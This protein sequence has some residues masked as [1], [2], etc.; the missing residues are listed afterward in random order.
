MFVSPKMTPA[1][2]ESTQEKYDAFFNSF[3]PEVERIT[4]KIGRSAVTVLFNQ[5]CLKEKTLPVRTYIYIYIYI[6]RP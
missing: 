2:D 3:H 1:A 5:T 6:Y 4:Y